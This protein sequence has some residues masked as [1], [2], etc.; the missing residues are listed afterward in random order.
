MTQ[1]LAGGLYNIFFNVSIMCRNENINLVASLSVFGKLLVS[2]SI[3]KKFAQGINHHGSLYP[4]VSPVWTAF[5]A[6][7]S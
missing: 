6:G 2:H 4:F 7:F 1:R 5:V 3:D